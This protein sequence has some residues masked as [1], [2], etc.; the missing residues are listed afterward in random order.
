[1]KKWLLNG[2]LTVFFLL[3]ASG[4]VFA[5]WVFKTQVDYVKARYFASQQAEKDGYG[6]FILEGVQPLGGGKYWAGFSTEARVGSY[7][8]H[9]EKKSG[10]FAITKKE[11]NGAGVEL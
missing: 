1:M 8:V 4:L 11:I 10:T 7:V 6:H 9:F 3:F 5:G 2:F